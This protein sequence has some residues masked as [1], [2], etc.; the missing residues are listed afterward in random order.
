MA[1][2]LF[3]ALLQELAVCVPAE[4]HATL[5]N[6]EDAHMANMFKLQALE[7]ALKAEDAALQEQ[8]AAAQKK[9]DAART[10]VV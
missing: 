1:T 8:L 5:M 10:L 9:Q 7:N 3:A 6:M 2:R 4:M